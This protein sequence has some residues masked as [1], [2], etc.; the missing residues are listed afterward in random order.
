MPEGFG[1]EEGGSFSTGRGKDIFSTK[2]TQVVKTAYQRDTGNE[3]KT[4]YLEEEEEQPSP[5]QQEEQQEKKA[6]LVL[7]VQELEKQKIPESAT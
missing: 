3:Q 1:G 6:A 7:L 5:Q 4:P 2:P